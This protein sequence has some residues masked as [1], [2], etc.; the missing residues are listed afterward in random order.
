MEK[1]FLHIISRLNPIE[2]IGVA[3]LLNIKVLEG[4]NARDFV[5]VLEEV[6]AE[7][8]RLPRRRKRNLLRILTPLLKGDDGDGR[9]TEDTETN[10]HD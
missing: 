8:Q 9:V 1:K 10:A 2:F 7:F 4:D 6:C 3:R 5:V